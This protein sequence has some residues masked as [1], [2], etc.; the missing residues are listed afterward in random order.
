MVSAE[1][2]YHEQLSG[3]ETTNSCFEPASMA[4]KCDPKL[5]KVDDAL[6]VDVTRVQT[7]LVAHP[8][9]H[10]MLTSY[11]RLSPQRRR[12]TSSSPWKEASRF[13]LE[14]SSFQLAPGVASYNSMI[15]AC[16]KYQQ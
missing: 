11:C 14:R 13:P 3:A 2:A 8:R 1:K 9:I 6:N 10:F 16:A 4:A 15:S 7:N 12:T 5:L